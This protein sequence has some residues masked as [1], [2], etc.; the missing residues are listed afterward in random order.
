MADPPR[1]YALVYQCGFANVFR[2]GFQPLLIPRLV[3]QHAFDYC[4][5]FCAGLIEAGCV[6]RV[7]HADVPGDCR[8]AGWADG[9][10]EMFAHAKSPPVH[11]R[12]EPN[13]D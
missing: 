9:P 13:E 7:Y 3:A 6:V 10:G 5:A 4:E 11:P 2:L 12:G 1:E 8:H